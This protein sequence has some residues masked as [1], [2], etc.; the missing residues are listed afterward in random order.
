MAKTLNKKNENIVISLT[1]DTVKLILILNK[2]Y[3]LYYIN[4]KN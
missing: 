1:N 2:Y 4:S 3:F